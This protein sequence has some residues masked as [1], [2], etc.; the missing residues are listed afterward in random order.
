MVAILQFCHHLNRTHR[1]KNDHD[2]DE[3]AEADNEGVYEGSAYEG[4]ADTDGVDEGCADEGGADEVGLY[5][6]DSGG[7]GEGYIMVQLGE[8]GEYFTEVRLIYIDEELLH[9]MYAAFCEAVCRL[10][11]KENEDY[12]YGDGVA[13]T[14]VL[15]HLD[16]MR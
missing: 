12:G 5:E 1:D 10:Q 6:G 4:G 8:L 9:A 7:G 13:E 11:R 3:D 14:S 16:R 15:V 2:L